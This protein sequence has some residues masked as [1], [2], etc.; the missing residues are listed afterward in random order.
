MKK[1]MLIFLMFLLAVSQ[2]FAYKYWD[3]HETSPFGNVTVH[4]KVCTTKKFTNN[5]FANWWINGYMSYFI[6]T[7]QN[8]MGLLQTQGNITGYVTD[9]LLDDGT[10]YRVVF[11]Y[12]NG[13]GQVIVGTEKIANVNDGNYKVPKDRSAELA[14]M[15]TIYDTGSQFAN[16]NTF[17][18]EYDRLCNK[19]L[20]ML[21]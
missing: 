9:V 6:S 1:R 19:Y 5:E 13:C 21:D 10:I 7:F 8:I 11:L 17:R 12:M 15:E 4:Y 20:N 14:P 2:V 3:K 18:A 16:F